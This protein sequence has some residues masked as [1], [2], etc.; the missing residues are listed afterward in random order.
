MLSNRVLLSLLAG[1]VIVVAV[2]STMGPARA[3]CAPLPTLDW[4]ISDQA[5]LITIIDKRYEGDWSKYVA[6]W[7]KQLSNMED[8]YDR[9]STA[10]IRSR[11]LKFSGEVLADYIV[12]IKSRLSTLRC[13][14]G[15]AGHELTVSQ[16]PSK[17]TKK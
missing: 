15:E 4:W 7:E 14:A 17:S 9:G 8:I 1:S 16:L 6:K 5:K 11:N 3:A 12:Q 10:V 2:F 13:L